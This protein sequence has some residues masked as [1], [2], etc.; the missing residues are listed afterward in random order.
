MKDLYC[1]NYKSLM[2]ETELRPK[3]IE[4]SMLMDWKNKYY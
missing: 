1:E 4:H 2:R 3:E